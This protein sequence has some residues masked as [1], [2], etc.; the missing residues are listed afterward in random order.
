MQS[1]DV[2]IGRAVKKGGWKL[3]ASIWANPFKRTKGLVPGSTLLAYEQYVRSNPNLMH[4]I[5]LL[6]GK[7][8]G[9]WCKPNPCHGDV[10]VK[11]VQEHLESDDSDDE[12]T[13]E[14]FTDSEQHDWSKDYKPASVLAEGVIVGTILS[15]SCVSVVAISDGH[16]IRPLPSVNSDPLAKVGTRFWFSYD[17]ERMHSHVRLPHSWKDAPVNIAHIDPSPI[18]PKVL[19][20]MIILCSCA[21]SIKQNE[22]AQELLKVLANSRQH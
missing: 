6:A 22:S 1:C 20:H 5:P 8:L 19:H 12:E 14:N 17:K 9:C 4:K 16:L 2:Y 18:H 7:T 10:L 21:V 3:D 11:L 15:P 13:E